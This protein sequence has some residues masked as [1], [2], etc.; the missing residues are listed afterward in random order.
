MCTV[1]MF[2]REKSNGKSPSEY[3]AIAMKMI[4]TK[5]ENDSHLENEYQSF[6]NNH[7][8]DGNSNMK[9]K[10]NL[11]IRSSHSFFYC[12][13]VI[14]FYAFIMIPLGLIV[15]ILSAK[16]CPLH[17]H[18]PHRTPAHEGESEQKNHRK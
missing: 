7:N 3:F 16:L 15:Y 12:V 18:T 13:F 10:I 5:Y 17:A 14:K 2:V 8:Y 9:N 11:T 1:S 4:K 6:A